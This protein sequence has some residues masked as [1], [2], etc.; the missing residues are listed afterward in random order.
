VDPIDMSSTSIMK[1]MI[2]FIVRL[3]FIV[4]VSYAAAVAVNGLSKHLL[5]TML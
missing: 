5:C 3:K 4:R 1:C 2:Q